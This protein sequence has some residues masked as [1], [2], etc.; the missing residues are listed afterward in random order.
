MAAS[1]VI[2]PKFLFSF[3]N[4]SCHGRLHIE[5]PYLIKEHLFAATHTS[6]CP[7]LFVPSHLS[8]FFVLLKPSVST[9]CCNQAFSF[10]FILRPCRRWW[11]H[12][13]AA[14]CW[15]T[16]FLPV[17]RGSGRGNFPGKSGVGCR[18]IGA[19][20]GRGWDSPA[21]HQGQG[22]GQGHGQGQ[23]QTSGVP[24]APHRARLH[25][26]VNTHIPSPS[27]YRA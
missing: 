2:E 18:R 25:R 11:E 27:W 16:L 4:S 19:W 3:Y 10:G 9:M 6:L 5:Q 23:G 15:E 8:L 13:T 1:Q 20:S 12:I 26:P 14:L 7:M 22:Q 17:T 24:I 21:G